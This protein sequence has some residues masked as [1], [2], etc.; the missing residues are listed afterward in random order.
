[1]CKSF[2]GG[3]GE[4]GIAGEKFG[5]RGAWWWGVGVDHCLQGCHS[6]W[7]FWKASNGSNPSRLQGSHSQEL[8]KLKRVQV[9][10]GGDREARQMGNLEEG[11]GGGG[12][13]GGGGDDHC[14][15]GWHS[16]WTF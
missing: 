15:E 2:E 6:N 1:M 14:L 8:G 10:G 16:Y 9:L 3:G 7:T 12:G 5:V 11:H 13:G 4:T